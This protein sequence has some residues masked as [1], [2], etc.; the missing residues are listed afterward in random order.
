MN[1]CF[2]LWNTD[3]VWIYLVIHSFTHSSIQAIYRVLLCPKDCE[4]QERQSSAQ[5]IQKVLPCCHS[6]SSQYLGCLSLQ[7]R[8][9][10]SYGFGYSV[11]FLC[12]QLSPLAGTTSLLLIWVTIIGL[13]YIPGWSQAGHLRL[14]YVPCPSKQL[15]HSYYEF[16]V[17]P[18][19]LFLLVWLNSNDLIKS[20]SPKVSVTFFLERQII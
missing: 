20:S 4:W 13:F 14:R 17:F 8:G 2:K 10:D 19:F 9:P 7:Q 3:V 11:S 5:N 18:P 15:L 1:N 12:C 6:H 16:G